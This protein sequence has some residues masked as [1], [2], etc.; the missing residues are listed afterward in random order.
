MSWCQ[1]AC[2]LMSFVYTEK[3]ITVPDARGYLQT[4]EVTLSCE[5]HGYQ[6]SLT[7][8]VWLDLSGSATT[9]SPKCTV[10]TV[11]SGEGG[12][13]II[14]EDGTT[15]PSMTVSLIIRDLSLADEGNYT[16]RGSNSQSVTQLF[17]V[18]G[19]APPPTTAVSSQSTQPLTT[20]STSTAPTS[21]GVPYS[22][23]YIT[24]Y[25]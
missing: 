15:V 12:R 18:E 14:L 21:E 2:L 8:P 4:G 16:C 20:A 3:I 10:S 11:S 6:L 22:T 5:L 19:T 17:I 13:T 1:A 7:P 25:V 9:T 23:C 24:M